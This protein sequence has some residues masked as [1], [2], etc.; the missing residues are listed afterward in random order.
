M[1]RADRFGATLA[2]LLA[3]AEPTPARGIQ[4]AT[5]P[6]SPQDSYVLA[7]GENV[8]IS[9]GSVET[10]I[11][12]RKR[13]R[14]TFLWARRNGRTVLIRDPRTL[15]RA[16]SLFEPLRATEPE[17]GSLQ[18]RLRRLQKE[19]TALESEEAYLDR[20]MDLASEGG[21]EPDTRETAG[22][23]DRRR[24]DLQSRMRTLEARASDLE[25]IEEALDRKA[26]ELEREAEK[27]LWDLVD[28]AISR[29]LAEP[30][31]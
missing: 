21:E 18:R 22:E 13:H 7:Y 28:E 9:S 31:R 16:E 20:R 26:D 15:A 12:V 8:S 30:A 24:R 2:L 19:Q 27:K 1:F 10:L 3:V 23:L 5:A 14:G 6:S 29:G 17:R 25:S 4:P 11:A